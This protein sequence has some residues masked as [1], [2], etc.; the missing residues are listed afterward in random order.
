MLLSPIPVDGLEGRLCMQSACW[1]RLKERHGW[2]AYAFRMQHST[3]LVLTRRFFWRFTLAYVPFG[4]LEDVDLANL[5][6]QLSPLLDGHLFAVRYDLPYGSAADGNGLI[7]QRESVQPDATVIIDL[8]PG[9]EVVRSR[10]RQRARRALRRSE[11]KVTV[12]LWDGDEKTFE[13]WYGVYEET[14]RR[15]GF[16]LRPRTYIR[17]VLSLGDGRTG[18]KLFVALRDGNVVGGTILLSNQE[19]SVYLFGASHRMPDCSAGYAL[20]DAMIRFSAETHRK[21]YDF[22][23]VSGENGRGAHLASLDLFKTSFGGDRIVRR[24]TC[25]WRV[26]RFVYGAFSFAERIRYQRSRGPAPR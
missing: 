16:S 25:D 3:L 1:A 18:S 2:K 8:T 26:D 6:R 20:Q 5:S 13:K 4:P 23:G 14:G 22:F 15:D 10:Y 9:Y 21:R 12:S 17:D 7:V 24:P 11:G 19:E